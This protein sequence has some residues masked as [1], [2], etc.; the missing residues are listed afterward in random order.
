MTDANG[1]QRPA[2]VKRELYRYSNRAEPAFQTQLKQMSETN[3]YIN[4]SSSRISNS[5]VL[6]RKPKA[7]DGVALWRAVQAA[8]TLEVN[9]AY[10]YLIFCSDFKETCLIAQD[11][12]DIAAFVIGYHPPGTADTLFCWQIAVLPPWRGT[13]LSQRL[14][15][16]WL[17]MPGNGEVR[18]VTATVADDNMASDRMFRRFAESLDVSCEVAAHFTTQLLPTGHRPELLYRIGPVEVDVGLRAR[19]QI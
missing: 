6:F 1:M 3:E 11:G 8:G 4:E 13:G 18:W 19:A 7:E 14:L 16:A 10:F 2:P 9:T 5:R 12:D 17:G 15:L